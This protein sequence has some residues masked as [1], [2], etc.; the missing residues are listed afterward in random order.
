MEIPVGYG[1]ETTIRP[2]CLKAYAYGW[3]QPMPSEVRTVLKI[4][5]LSNA[6]AAR[7]VGV[8]DGR[9]LRRWTS[10]ES[11][12]PYSAWAVLCEAAGFG[13]IW[14]FTAAPEGGNAVASSV[15]ALV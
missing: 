10:G 11:K 6:E 2:G 7:L 13:R 5:G 14:T 8:S 15:D 4:A 1:T 3:M 12:V 9:I